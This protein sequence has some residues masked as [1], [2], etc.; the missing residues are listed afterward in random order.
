MI[1]LRLSPRL[2]SRR[3]SIGTRCRER[4]CRY[5]KVLWITMNVT[6]SRDGKLMSWRIDPL[7]SSTMPPQR[8]RQPR[9]TCLTTGALD[10]PRQPAQQPPCLFFHP[11][12]H[13][14]RL[15]GECRQAH[16]PPYPSF[17]RVSAYR[18]ISGDHHPVAFGPQLAHPC[19]VTWVPTWVAATRMLETMTQES[20]HFARRSRKIGRLSPIEVK[21]HAAS[22]TAPS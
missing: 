8:N 18:I 13:P 7:Q 14:G 17:R 22:R 11:R 2:S 5:D 3:S 20:E 19:D 6:G 9:P 4:Y 16:L 21:P 15:E 1:E 12:M 10:Q